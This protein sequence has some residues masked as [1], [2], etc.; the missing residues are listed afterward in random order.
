MDWIAELAALDRSTR[1]LCVSHLWMGASKG[2][3][4]PPGP[5]GG[6]PVPLADALAEIQQDEAVCTVVRWLLLQSLSMPPEGL[7]GLLAAPSPADHRAP[8]DVES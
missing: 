2:H 8:V 1:I 4:L 3:L 5:R 7:A 6:M